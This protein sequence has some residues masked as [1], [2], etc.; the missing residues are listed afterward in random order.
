MRYV[1]QSERSSI[2]TTLLLDTE[3]TVC[4]TYVVRQADLDEVC[5]PVLSSCHD[6]QV[7]LVAVGQ[8]PT[9]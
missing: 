2:G 1:L 6:H 9:R 3:A 8:H 4:V 5:C 7:A